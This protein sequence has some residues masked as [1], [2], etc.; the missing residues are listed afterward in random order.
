VVD[1]DERRVALAQGDDRRLVRD[2]QELAVAL[3]QARAGA[4]RGPERRLTGEA[5]MA[6]CSGYEVRIG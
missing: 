5:D 3:E 1:V 2:R 6:D 4:E